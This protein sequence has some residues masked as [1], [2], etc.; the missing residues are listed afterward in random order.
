M[1]R[2][3]SAPANICMLCHNKITNKNISEKKM[4]Y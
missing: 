4:Y 1:R 3:K 2:I